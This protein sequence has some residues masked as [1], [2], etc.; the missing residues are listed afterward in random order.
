MHLY[1]RICA[2]PVSSV[3]VLLSTL[4]TERRFSTLTSGELFRQRIPCRK[5]TGPSTDFGHFFAK[6][7]RH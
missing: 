4:L 5:V 6:K 3:S 7:V 2:V 1:S